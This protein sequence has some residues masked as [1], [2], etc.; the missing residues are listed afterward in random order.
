MW[1]P[2]VVP[3]AV[4]NMV[5][6]QKCQNSWRALRQ[7]GIFL[8]RKARWFN[9]DGGDGNCC[10]F[11]S[12]QWLPSFIDIPLEIG[13]Q[14]ESPVD[15]YFRRYHFH[16][17]RDEKI[18]KF[19][20][21]IYIYMYIFI[22]YIYIYTSLDIYI[23][24]IY[25]IYIFLF[26]SE[27]HSNS[28]KTQQASPHRGEEIFWNISYRY[29]HWHT[30]RTPCLRRGQ[31][32]WRP[33][34]CR[35][36]MLPSHRG[37]YCGTSVS[38]LFMRILL[39]SASETLKLIWL[40]IPELL[41]SETPWICSA[42]PAGFAWIYGYFAM[43][44]KMSPGHVGTWKRQK[45]IENSFIIS[46]PLGILDLFQDCFFH[47]PYFHRHQPDTSWCEDCNIEPSKNSRSPSRLCWICLIR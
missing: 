9:L 44:S 43:T 19:M 8:A 12:K 42:N 36:P 33:C 26:H 47:T 37:P 17:F 14:H 35:F 13:G 40:L 10:L 39:R 4:W 21:Y 27:Q 7:S 28:V 1:L 24:V 6:P 3:F 45:N 5:L 2:K 20:F 15:L 46:F 22:L 34:P 31:G 11:S 32:G 38:D 41:S 18:V 23:Y 16:T 29:R 30:A 25:Y